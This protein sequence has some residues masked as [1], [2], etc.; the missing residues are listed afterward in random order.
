[1]EFD[2]GLEKIRRGCIGKIYYQ[3]YRKVTFTDLLFEIPATIASRGEF[4]S[5]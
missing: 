4:K 2:T 3:D 5:I 1:L